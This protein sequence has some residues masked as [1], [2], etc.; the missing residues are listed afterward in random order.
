LLLLLTALLLLLQRRAGHVVGLLLRALLPRVK[1]F[2]DRGV[3]QRRRRFTLQ[4][5]ALRRQHGQ[6]SVSQTGMFLEQI[7]ACRYNQIRSVSV[8]LHL[9]KIKV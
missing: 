3:R 6:R 9:K 7:D 8:D 5:V 2:A 1:P 4:F